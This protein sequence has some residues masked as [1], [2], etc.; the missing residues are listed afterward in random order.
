M[1]AK[2]KD[3]NQPNLDTRLRD[4]EVY[5]ISNKK[6]INSV[7]LGVAAVILAYVG[8]IYFYINPQQE[9][10][11]KVMHY[12]EAYYVQDS[13]DLA[14]N[15]DNG[16]NPGLVYI[17]N[18]YGATAKGSL[19]AYMAATIYMRNGE[20][21]TAIDY[22]KKYTGDDF[23]IAVNAKG[24]I[25]DANAE[26]GNYE[27]AA[28]YY[29]EAANMRDNVLLSPYYLQKAAQAYEEIGNKEAALEAYKAIKKDYKESQQGEGV[30]KDIYR[31]ET[32]LGKN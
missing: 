9:A 14:L 29:M 25:G 4:L 15:G 13:F 8:Y 22:F 28:D 21:E 7:L 24:G 18:E 17:A 5:Y 10:V 6:R 32:I 27:E 11:S 26:L 31:L 1:S 30:E 19:A 23:M 3:S 20:F 16:N 12:A 2:E